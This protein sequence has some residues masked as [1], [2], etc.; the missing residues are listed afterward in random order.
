MQDGEV[1]LQVDDSDLNQPIKYVLLPDFDM[2]RTAEGQGPC[3][4]W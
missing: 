1:K 4:E 3:Y 2:Q